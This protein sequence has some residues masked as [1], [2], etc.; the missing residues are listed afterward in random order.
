MGF[1]MEASHYEINNFDTSS[2]PEEYSLLNEKTTVD[3]L[4]KRRDSLLNF[5]LSRHIN[6]A[7]LM[8]FLISVAAN[9][10]SFMF[11]MN[12]KNPGTV[13]RSSYGL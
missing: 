9:I 13:C 1:I 10:A 12:H 5:S 7:L 6:K 3:N 2:D 8:L 11:M 4:K